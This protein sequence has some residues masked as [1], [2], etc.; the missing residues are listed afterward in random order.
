ME[1]EN[2]QQGEGNWKPLESNPTVINEYI[3]NLGF[4][5]SGFVFQ[6]IFSVEEWA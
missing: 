2:Q 6:D 3:S 4:D 5:T 1:Q